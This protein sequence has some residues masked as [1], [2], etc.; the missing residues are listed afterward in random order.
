MAI[1]CFLKL[2][3]NIKGESQDA[4]HIDWIDVLSW[5]WGMTQSGTTHMGHGGGGGKVDVQDITVSKYVDAATH[6][7]IKRCCSGEHISA[8]QLVV[9]K[10]G[11]AAPIDY[12]TIDF[13]DIMISSYSTGG[14]KDG[15][16]RVQ[17]TLTLNFRRFEVTYTVQE[18][19]GT[20]GPQ[21]QAG[22]EIAEN[23]EWSA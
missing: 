19:D 21:S 23:V 7:L 10:S 3:N 16:D 18:Q 6:D 12:L 8:G 22:W 2:E 1:D 4:G 9:R 13:E 15:L 14:M 20:A 5:N 11:G 17:E